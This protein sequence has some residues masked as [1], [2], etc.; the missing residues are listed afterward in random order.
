MP[1]PKGNKPGRRYQGRDSVRHE[2]ELLAGELQA[3][4]EDIAAARAAVARAHSGL[5]LH[6]DPQIPPPALDGERVTLPDGAEVV[7]RTLRPDDVAQLDLGFEHLSAVSRY[8]RFRTR[9]EHLR[10]SDLEELAHPDHRMYEVLGAFDPR[11]GEGVGMAR[12]VRDH[13]DP[14]TAEVDYVVADAW[15][16]R[17]VAT[18]LLERLAACARRYGV[19][20][21][22]ATTIV[23]DEPARHALEH[24]A[25]PVSERRES[26][27]VHITARLHGAQVDWSRGHQ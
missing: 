13:A 25:D 12:Y 2:L 10:R 7:V 20:R 22:T 16:H 14:S 19:Q 17:G 23:G 1:A 9:V 21:V 5:D 11:A 4:D 6:S 8:R 15:H 26:G 18:V 3:L 24:I 27:I